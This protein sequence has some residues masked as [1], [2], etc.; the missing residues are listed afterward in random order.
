[1]ASR[2]FFGYDPYDYYYPS[3][4]TYT[5]PYDSYDSY[6]HPR[7]APAR[8]PARSQG[9]FFRDAEIPE[10]MMREYV[11]PRP[12]STRPASIPIEVTG[13]DSEPPRKAAPVLK[14]RAPSA[15]AAA[16]KV[17]AAARGLLARRMMREVRAVEREAEAVAARVAAEA[18]A[19]SAD[20]RKRIGVGEELM[21]LVL[22]LDAVRGVREYRKK[23]TRKV[24][25][26]QDA[27]DAL[28]ATPA[29]QEVPPAAA[30]AESMAADTVEMSEAHDALESGMTPELQQPGEQIGSDSFSVD[31]TPTEMDME[32]DGG[33]AEEPDSAATESTVTESVA[34]GEQAEGDGELAAEAEEEWEMVTGDD[35]IDGEP[36]AEQQ[37]AAA[38]E[39]EEKK[40]TEAATAEGL[41]AKKMMEMVAALCERSAQQCALIGALAERVDTLERAVR[42]VEEADRRRRRIKK[43]KKEGKIDG[44]AGN[45]FY[46]D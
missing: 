32:V 43:I 39:T 9:A 7:P 24:L 25:A 42:R 3:P 10:P 33:R 19:L 6:Y 18:E 16:V 36:K 40:T 38:E 4:S 5:Y 1:M 12:T 21:R 20:S 41:D 34:A 45:S 23:V 14:K 37:E 17:Q 28:E 44:K 22:R 11:R 8:A 13:P 15:E 46:S 27:V 30:D 29:H 2:G 31:A 26:L 35:A